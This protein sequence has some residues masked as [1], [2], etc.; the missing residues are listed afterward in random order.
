MGTGIYNCIC[1]GKEID[2][3]TGYIFDKYD[4][5]YNTIKKDIEDL[6]SRSTGE[7]H[8]GRYFLLLHSCFFPISLSLL[9]E[10]HYC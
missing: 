7:K 9:Y 1:G 8:W 2:E 10:Q 5:G 4:V 3:I 6:I